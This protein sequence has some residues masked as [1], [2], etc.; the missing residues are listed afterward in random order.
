MSIVYPSARRSDD[1]EVFHSEF[2]SANPYKWLEDD[3]ESDEKSAWLDAQE[4]TFAAFMEPHA[5]ARARTLA[6]LTQWQD[7]AKYGVPFQRGALHFF[8]KNSGLQ[9]Q[10]VLYA[11]RRTSDP[12]AD[13]IVVL[14]PNALAADG[15]AAVGSMA[16]S[17]DG[18]HLAYGISNAGSDWQTIHVRRIDAATMRVCELADTL[19]WAKFTS[20]AWAHDGSGFFYARYPQPATKDAGTETAK[21]EHQRV[22]WHTLGEAQSEDVLVCAAPDEPE[23][24]FGVEVSD[25]GRTLI[26]SVSKDCEPSNLVWLVDIAT[27]RTA[28]PSPTGWPVQT[29][30]VATFGFAFNYVANDGDQF[31]FLTNHSAP[32]YR[33]VRISVAGG[34]ASMVDVVAQTK[35]LLEG[36]ICVSQD[37]LVLQYLVD[38][39]S[40]LRVHALTDGAFL[41]NVALSG[42]GCV[43]GLSAR[44][45][46]TEV[47]FKFVSFLTPGDIY[48]CDPRSPTTPA[49]L[50]RR[51]TVPGFDA[52]DYQVIQEFAVSRDGTR[53]P[54][55]IVASKNL[56]R[57]SRNNCICY[58]YGGF[59]ISLPPSFSTSRLLWIRAGGIYV[60]TNL[61]GGG[62]YGRDW[63]SAGTKE[64][65]QNVFD[66]FIACIEHVVAQKYTAPNK[67][68][69]QGGSNGGLLVA[70]VMNQRPDLCR[71]VVCQV[72][73]LDMLRYQRF[74]IGH[75]WRSDYGDADAD[76]ATFKYMNAYSPL[77]NVPSGVQLPALLVM[78]ADHDDR[79]SPLHS[80]KFIAQ[81]QHVAG[82]TNK[83][84]LLMRVERRAG[85]GAGLPLAKVLA[86]TADLLV[87]AEANLKD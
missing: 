81:V 41:A 25:D 64:K 18:T 53:V 3:G 5:E 58:G 34:V 73:V 60:Q 19:L 2:A 26:V 29:K 43:S 74:G 68:V 12:D 72:G 14:D 22:Y 39:A 13:A 62:E 78:T 23:W 67:V 47:F 70:A 7:H 65:K 30:L 15:T 20:I 77:H 56:E 50:F 28:P 33:V 8:W 76:A 45:R 17:D 31:Y 44:R 21:V 9:N 57:N 80:F 42:I 86:S 32:L 71:A 36:V 54:M 35:D 1:V 69:I 46:D 11:V 40:Q 10:S 61:R 37:R 16:F 82:A 83:A 4:R 6:Q 55:F 52:D 84:P 38:V 85:H 49:R 27:A 75:A 48:V 51:I 63:H 66:D 24:M 59:N 79:V 87:F